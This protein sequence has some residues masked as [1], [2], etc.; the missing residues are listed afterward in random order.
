[1]MPLAQPVTDALAHINEQLKHVDSY[2]DL[3]NIFNIRADAY[4]PLIADAKGG[5]LN[6]MRLIRM[7]E[8]AY[9]MANLPNDPKKTYAHNFDG[10]HDHVQNAFQNIPQLLDQLAQADQQLNHPAPGTDDEHGGNA[11]PIVKGGIAGSL[12]KSVDITV[13]KINQEGRDLSR[14]ENVKN[15]KGKI[16]S[17]ILVA[18]LGGEF[19]GGARAYSRARFDRC[20]SY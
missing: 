9:N 5:D 11:R 6:A 7:M 15:I 3:K 19:G 17:P 8:E 18:G 1:M 13:K 10:L 2:Q 14:L 4:K 20:R 16:V 12:L